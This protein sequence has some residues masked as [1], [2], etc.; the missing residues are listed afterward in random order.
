MIDFKKEFEPVL[1]VLFQHLGE[2]VSGEQIAQKFSIS[3][4]AVQKRV[5]KL[6]QKG[7]SITATPKKGFCLKPPFP[8]KILPE[9]I[10]NH[11]TYDIDCYCLDQ[12]T[13]TNKI[14]M[15]SNIQEPFILFTREQIEGKGR[16]GRSWNMQREKDIAITFSM[17]MNVSYEQI[18]SLLHI[19]SVAVHKTLD[20]YAPNQIFIKWPNDLI[21]ESGKKIAG[22][23]TT[24]VT[25]DNIFKRIIVGI[26]ININSSNL[27]NY[28]V[29]LQNLINQEIDINKIYI[30]LINNF[31]EFWYNFSSYQHYIEERWF[32]LLAWKDEEVVLFHNDNQFI[33]IFKNVQQ[34][35]AIIL[36]INGTDQVFLTGDL[37]LISLRKNT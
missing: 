2:Y 29:S 14:A 6:I 7:Y 35:G 8:Y 33:G 13:S 5:E 19:A 32:K 36:N 10:A 4:S 22:I 15:E 21:S 20:L 27:P 37:N 12:S 9:Y 26:G 3:R 25:E 30:C 1:K 16:A 31:L 23:L 11:I 28:A 18:S 17:P 34:D 24:T